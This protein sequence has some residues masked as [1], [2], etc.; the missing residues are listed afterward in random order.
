MDRNAL[1]DRVHEGIIVCCDRRL[2]PTLDRLYNN[3]RR[4]IVSTGGANV[5]SVSDTVRELTVNG[6]RRWTVLAHTDTTDI[7]KG[8]R[9]V[10]QAAVEVQA[11]LAGTK[12]PQR[13]VDPAQVDRFIQD[14]LT[15]RDLI[16]ANNLEFQTG[17]LRALLVGAGAHVD[18]GATLDTSTMFSDD[19]LPH[20]LVI[21]GPSA[22][23]YSSMTA[24][25]NAHGVSPV[26]SYNTF[27]SQVSHFQEAVIDARVFTG[28][29]QVKDVRLLYLSKSDRLR[30]ARWKSGLESERFMK[31]ISLAEFELSA[32][33]ATR[34]GRRTRA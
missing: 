22:L 25:L 3:E 16:E 8:C 27:Y 23:K 19:V 24:A 33:G 12:L 31:G 6:V 10:G 5:A 15:T 21:T 30:M 4:V 26:G 9:W 11:K 28:P 17:A 7:A 14:G 18:S 32:P 20:V 2:R 13:Y 29:L 34:Y 1:S